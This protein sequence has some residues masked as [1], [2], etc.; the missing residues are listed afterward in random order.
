MTAT[1]RDGHKQWPWRPQPWWP[2]T[3]TINLVK[4]IQR[5]QWIWR[6]L[7]CM[8]LVFTFSFLWPSRYTL[9][10][11][12]F[13]AVLGPW[14]I[15]CPYGD[16]I[17]M[18]LAVHSLVTGICD[19]NYMAIKS[20]VVTV[21]WWIGCPYF[22]RIMISLAVHSLVTGICDSNIWRSKASEL[23]WIGCPC[24]D[25]IMTKLAFHNLMVPLK[26]LGL[27][28]ILAP[29]NTES[30]HFSEIQPS[31]APVKRICRIWQVPVQ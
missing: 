25:W 4:F 10:P 14:W 12:W 30:S 1:N 27:C 22:D 13:V 7:K 26:L 15:S 28:R 11:S 5:R 6:F 21:L 23:W 29:T 3:V 8:P 18:S 24:V 9:W 19:S 31:P 16:W 17:I 2:H 20:I